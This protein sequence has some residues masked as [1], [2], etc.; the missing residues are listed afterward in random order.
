M[1]TTTYKNR[2]ISPMQP[3][4]AMKYKSLDPSDK[5]H[6]LRAEVQKCIGAYDIT[7]EFAEDTETI[8]MFKHILGLVA[9]VCTLKKGGKII[10][11]GRGTAVLSN[12]NRYAERT[13]H[14]A[15]NSS[16]IDAIVRSTKMLD[17]FHPDAN[18]QQDMGVA[19]NLITDKQQSYL[20]EL[21]QTGI[22]DEE[23]RSRWVEQIGGLTKEEASEAIQSFKR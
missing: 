17:A 1:N 14:T 22:A 4:Q 8:G 7:A 19:F 21:I 15:F 2:P 5:N 23:E 11:Q 3:V 9:F 18:S 20:L 10:G 16:L 12:M 6:P 13:V